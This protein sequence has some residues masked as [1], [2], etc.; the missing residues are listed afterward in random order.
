MTSPTSLET[1]TNYQAALRA[2]Q[3]AMD[4]PVEKY[5][6]CRAQQQAFPAEYELICANFG[7]APKLMHTYV[8]SGW[9]RRLVADGGLHKRYIQLVV[10]YLDGLREQKQAC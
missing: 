8:D 10:C 9:R 5:A 3:E 6:Y 1:L 2:A 4:W 7:I